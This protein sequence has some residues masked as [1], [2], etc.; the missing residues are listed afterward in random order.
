MSFF[1]RTVKE[2]RPLGLLK[3]LKPS[4]AVAG[5]DRAL[6]AVCRHSAKNGLM[7]TVAPSMLAIGSIGVAVEYYLCHGM[8]ETNWLCWAMACANMVFFGFSE[9]HGT[10]KYV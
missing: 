9:R 10:A 5:Y 1:T 2:M 6:L 8:R 4:E 7:A 3:Y